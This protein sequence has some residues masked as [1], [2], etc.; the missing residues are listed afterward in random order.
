MKSVNEVAVWPAIVTVILPAVLLIGTDV[1]ILVG[2]LL[3]TMAV[4][5]LKLTLLFAFTLLKPVPVIATDV[6]TAPM[7]GVKDAMAKGSTK[8]SV[9]FSTVVLS[10]VTL[11]FPVVAPGGTVTVK[12]VKVVLG[13]TVAVTPL[14]LTD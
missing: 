10:R 8:N 11:I 1:V 3:V 2:E 12:L 4:V 5:P 13:L 14:N 9:E 7:D 6:P